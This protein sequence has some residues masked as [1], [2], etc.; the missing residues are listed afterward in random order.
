MPVDEGFARFFAY[1]NLFMCAMLILVL[2]DSLVL[3]FVGWEG[4]GLCSYLLIG[5]WFDDLKNAD[6]GK[7][8]FIVNRVGDF[9]FILGMLTLLGLS[10]TLTFTGL[11]AWTKDYVKRPDV[12][13]GVVLAV[14]ALLLFVGACGK[15]AQIPLYV[16]L[17]DAMAGPTP[18]SAL[19]HA[20]TMV[21]A[22]VY[23][24]GR[25]HFLYALAP[26]A[27]DVIVMIGAG[28]A[29]LAAVIAVAQTDI[30]K[31]L[32]YS[33]VSQLGFMFAGMA[34]ANFMTGM[35]HVTTHAFF[36]ALL[37]LGAGAVIHALHGQQDIRKMGG[38]AKSMPVLFA[39]FLAGGLALMGCPGSAG[40]YSKDLILTS[41]GAHEGAAFQGAWLML[42]GTA[43]LTA[44]Y[45]MRMLVIVFF[46]P[47]ADPESHPHA[48]GITMMAPLGVL[49]LLSVVGGVAL[50]SHMHHALEQVWGATALE[51]T[52]A[53]ADAHHKSVAVS[54]AVF[55]CGALLSF[56]L[57]GL[58]RDWVEDFVQGETGRGVHKLVANKFYVDEIYQWTIVAPVRVGAAAL[59]YIVDRIL[60]DAVLV[61][62]PARL[63]YGVGGLVRRAHTGAIAA[64]AAAMAMGVIA[65]LGWLVWRFLA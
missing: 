39:F 6:A 55:F 32:A 1:L 26:G 61:G 37:F 62:G 60:I 51:R 22:G 64:G 9:G 19:I 10:G 45:T 52:T 34:S 42:V 50:E 33:T 12:M 58:R 54:W 25:M 14:P 13:A 35:F 29:L 59:W 36:K 63:A 57:Y 56:V 43:F 38:L 41:V 2:G 8:A 15:S 16:W 44:F 5:F 48:P 30:K 31:I 21:T 53:F 49:A 7:K 3:M 4:V 27:M 28:T 40:F 65:T 18:V 11:E 23:M 47:P 17:P 46:G 24:V 20:A